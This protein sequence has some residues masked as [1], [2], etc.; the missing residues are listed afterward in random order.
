MKY[1]RKPVVVE[2]EQF[3]GTGECAVR[4]YLVHL[5]NATPISRWFCETLEG[6]LEA[7]EGTW[8]ITGQDGEHWPVAADKFDALY[9]PVAE[10]RTVERA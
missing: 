9:E 3:D 4:L 2:A 10:A 7:K 1:R 8:I 6:P 5:N